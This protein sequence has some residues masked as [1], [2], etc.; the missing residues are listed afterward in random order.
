MKT[1][2]AIVNLGFSVKLLFEFF[3]ENLQWLFD[4]PAQI[5]HLLAGVG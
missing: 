4:D 2:S 5:A 1:G 3:A